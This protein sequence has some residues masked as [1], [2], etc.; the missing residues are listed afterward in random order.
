LFEAKLNADKRLTSGIFW[1]SKTQRG[2][3]MHHHLT[4]NYFQMMHP[5]SSK[6]AANDPAYSTLCPTSKEV[7]SLLH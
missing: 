4:W 3:N 6:W 1:S 2:H 7:L 5:A